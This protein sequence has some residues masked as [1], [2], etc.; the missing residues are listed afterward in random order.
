MNRDDAKKMVKLLSGLFDSKPLT[1]DQARYA[2]QEFRAF[3]LADVE[4]AIR[5]H[6]GQYT[7][8]EWP[9]LLEACR[10]PLREEADRTR[11]ATKGAV[12]VT[13]NAADESWCDVRRRQSPQLQNAGDLEVIL[14]V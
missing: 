10:A 6:R 12:P 7:F 4:R 5:E 11:A 3:E 14:R 8:I 13:R 9:E 1:E 2:A